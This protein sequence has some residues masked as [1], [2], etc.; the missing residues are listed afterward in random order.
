M[1][2]LLV[3]LIFFVTIMGT[4]YVNASETVTTYRDDGNATIWDGKWS[5]VQE[6]KKTSYT[7]ASGMVLRIGHDYK[8]LYVFLDAIQQEEFTRNSDYGVI[9]I[10]PNTFIEHLPQNDDHCFLV[11]LGTSNA[12][13]LQGG[14]TL[15]LTDYYS[16][17]NNDPRLVAVSNISDDNDRYTNNPHPSYEFRIPI[18]LIGRSDNYHFYA[19]TYDAA[20]NL[21]AT[22]PEN[23]IVT[24]FP[25]IPIPSQWGDL[26]SP[27]KSIP[28]F[29]WPLFSLILSFIPVLVI[30][31]KKHIK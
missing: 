25:N 9:C 19:A 24:K 31:W 11:S 29:S 21:L 10:T 30:N 6:W 7:D 23:I 1:K 27:D 8:Y 28:E 17:I 18:E 5:F 26:T 3:G 22:W 14:S 13:T 16:R 12:I 15:G 2:F 4:S 20:N